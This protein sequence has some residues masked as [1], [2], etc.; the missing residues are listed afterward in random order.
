MTRAGDLISRCA[1]SHA[2][3]AA[4][5]GV[6]KSLVTRWRSG[7]RRPSDEDMATLERLYGTPEE[8]EPPSLD[9]PDA[10]EPRAPRAPF[11]EDEK[12]RAESNND[13]LHRYIREGMRELENDTELSGVK[14]AEALKKL[15]DAQV[16]L[17]RS[18]GENALTMTRIVAHPEFRRCVRLVVD[19]VS[20]FPDALRAVTKALDAAGA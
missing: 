18:T 20:P 11:V 16:A 8:L 4:K 17:D 19:A 9:E 2:E 13:R 3:I 5:L 7:A 6:D 10:V 12:D 1:D 14:R 15:V